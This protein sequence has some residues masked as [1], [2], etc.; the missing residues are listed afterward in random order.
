MTSALLPCAA[1]SRRPLLRPG[2][3]TAAAPCPLPP[4]PLLV[5]WRPPPLRPRL[6]RARAAAAGA[7]PVAACWPAALYLPA[8]AD[9]HAPPRLWDTQQVRAVARTL[10]CARRA[11]LLPR[12]GRRSAQQLARI[13][14][15]HVM[16]AAGAEHARVQA[17]QHKTARACDCV[18]K[19]GRVCLIC[20]RGFLWR[21]CRQPNAIRRRARRPSCR[22]S[23]RRM[24]AQLP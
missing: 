3:A 20:R 1:A 8:D 15:A 7:P 9:A 12:A 17:A 13:L 5:V 16:A 23:P 4:P 2:A 6:L 24:G 21:G 19:E 14:C 10:R 22:A 18:C 11:A